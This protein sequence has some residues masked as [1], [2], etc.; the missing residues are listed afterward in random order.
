MIL[1]IPITIMHISNILIIIK[2]R[3][4]HKPGYYL[5]INLSTADLLMVITTSIRFFLFS[6]TNY[7]ISMLQGFFFYSSLLSTVLI[8]IDRYIAVIHC[9]TIL[10]INFCTN[11]KC[12]QKCFSANVSKVLIFG[13]LVRTGTIN[14]FSC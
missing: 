10:D 2:K 6:N 5:L 3:H 12:G 13:L 7:Y 14:D 11:V 9:L 4:L 8:S 1:T